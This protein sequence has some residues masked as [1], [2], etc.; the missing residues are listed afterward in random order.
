MDQLLELYFPERYYL[1][2]QSKWSAY[3]CVENT[4]VRLWSHICDIIGLEFKFFKNIVRCVLCGYEYMY[5]V[6]GFICCESLLSVDLFTVHHT[7]YT[8]S[9]RKLSDILRRVQ[10]LYISKY[11]KRD[12]ITRWLTVGSLRWNPDWYFNW[13][14]VVNDKIVKVFKK[15][16]S[17]DFTYCHTC[18]G[19]ELIVRS[20]LRILFTIRYG[21]KL[22]CFEMF[23]SFRVEL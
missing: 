21:I 15:N 16:V 8:C 14:F 19:Y 11:T 22:P 17:H 4:F 12:I 9:Y 5:I 10:V 1:R 6:L 7:A 13:D 2:S 20:T 18:Y 3:P 23:R